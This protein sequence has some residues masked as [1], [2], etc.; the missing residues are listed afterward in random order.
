MA[1]GRL[2]STVEL[3]HLHSWQARIGA[4]PTWPLFARDCWIAQWR[5]VVELAD[6]ADGEPLARGGQLAAAARPTIA[7]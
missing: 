6:Q 2:T 7:R 5:I 1:A 4:V 3:D